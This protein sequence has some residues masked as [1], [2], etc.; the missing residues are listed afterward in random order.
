MIRLEVWTV[1]TKVATIRTARR[2]F[3]TWVATVRLAV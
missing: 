1:R 2:A 3:Q